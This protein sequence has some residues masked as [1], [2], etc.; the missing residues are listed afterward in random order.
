MSAVKTSPAQTV[1]DV[2]NQAFDLS[3]TIED[4]RE[5]ARAITDLLRE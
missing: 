1:R 4:C 3:L 2:L 5:A